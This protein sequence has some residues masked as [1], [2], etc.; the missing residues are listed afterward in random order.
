MKRRVLLSAF[1]LALT[2]AFVALAARRAPSLQADTLLG[3]TGTRNYRPALAEAADGTAILAWLSWKAGAGAS[4]FVA[5]SRDGVSW[6]APEELSEKPGPLFRPVLVRDGGLVWCFWSESGDLYARSWDGRWGPR[7][8]ITNHPGPDFNV[9]AAADPAGGLTIVWQALRDGN[10][11]IF[12][13]RRAKGAWSEEVRL[14]S[15]P[16]GDWDPVVASDGEGL[17]CV[18]SAFT[19]ADYDLHARRWTASGG[20]GPVRA[21]RDTGSY[22]LHPTLGGAGETGKLL[23]AWDAVRIRD[24]DAGAGQWIEQPG[25]RQATLE[26]F[27]LRAGLLGPDGLRAAP[28]PEARWIVNGGLAKVGQASG[29]VLACYRL[30]GPHNERGGGSSGWKLALRTC[31]AGGW[32]PD[33]VLDRRTSPFE[34]PAFLVGREAVWVAWM[35]AEP[36]PPLRGRKEEPQP[37]EVPAD[38]RDHLGPFATATVGGQEARIRVLRAPLP[39]RPRGAETRLVPADAPVLSWS[40]FVPVPKPAARPSMEVDGQTYNLYW[41]DLHRH[42]QISRC[43]QAADPTLSDHYKYALDVHHFDFFAMTDHA[44]HTNPYHYWETEEFADLHYVPGTLATLHGFEWSSGLGTGLKRYGH[45]NVI[46]PDRV[47]LLPALGKEQDPTGLW[48]A[49]EGRRV[50]TIPHHPASFIATDWSFHHP[51]MQRLVEI[52]SVHWGSAEHRGAPRQCTRL[53][54]AAVD[55]KWVDQALA[56]G[57]KMGF[58]AS[59]DHGYGAAYAAVWAKGCD[60]DSIFEA[61]R[62]RRAYGS[63]V[64]GLALEFRVN[65]RPMGEEIAGAQGPRKLSIKVSAPSRIAK[66]IVFR[67]AGAAWTFEAEGR[68]FERSL[69]DDKDLPAPT[70]YYFRVELADGELG[71]S[72]PVWVSP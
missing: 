61:L 37:A 5:R 70:W 56:R 54:D 58:I 23:L 28:L 21:L 43:H 17:W 50:V 32:G 36:R 71:W 62:S 18:W 63:T 35:S 47:P 15:N 69:E 51:E 11:E 33:V 8:K 41:G 22:A 64:H 13:R 52:Y 24:H 60:R 55:D 6:S 10:F 4:L 44:E 34:E 9:E 45:K 46:S 57:Y 25:V 67:G 42:S 48:K 53:R 7:Q 65:G 14:S 31:R 26:S 38:V 68:R 16:A 2:G 66:V 39:E 27:E 3:S 72:S 29:E 40:E 12:A 49:L 59:S 30:P 20:W 1:L 19:D